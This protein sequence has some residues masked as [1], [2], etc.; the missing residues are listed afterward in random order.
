MSNVLS[1]DVYKA[2]INPQA[3]PR[4]IVRAG[5]I[6]SIGIT[7][8]AFTMGNFIDATGFGNTDNIFPKQC[9]GAMS[10]EHT[11]T[12]AFVSVSQADT[13]GGAA[14]PRWEHNCRMMCSKNSHP[15]YAVVKATASE[16]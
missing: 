13:H 5:E 1:L 11:Q 10:P 2:W 3:E 4:E 16:R 9:C 6:V 14:I 8:V 15:E 7:L 12:R